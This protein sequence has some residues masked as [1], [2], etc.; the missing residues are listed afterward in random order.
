MTDFMNNLGSWVYTCI[1]AYSPWLFRSG[2]IVFTVVDDLLC[3]FSADI[4][5]EDI[6]TFI[7][8]LT[9]LSPDVEVVTIAKNDIMVKTPKSR[10]ET[11]ERECNYTFDWDHSVKLVVERPWKAYFEDGTG[12]VSKYYLAESG[13]E[14]NDATNVIHWLECTS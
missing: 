3:T 9:T 6:K 7:D 8:A 10:Y 11:W 14:V 4:S 5:P 12:R 1:I 2:E 13:P